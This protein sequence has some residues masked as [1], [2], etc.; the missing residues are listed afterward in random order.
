MNL[1]NKLTIARLGLTFFFVASFAFEFQ[2]RFTVAFCIFLTAAI[3]DFLDGEIARREN[4][5]TDFGKLMDPLADKILTASAFISLAAFNAIP[6]WAVI[7]IIS[8]EFL[9]TGLRTLAASK[10]IMLPADKLGKHKTTWQMITIIFFLLILSVGEF[11]KADWLDTAWLIGTHLLVPI[12]VILSLYSGLA[13]L[14]KNR[15]LLDGR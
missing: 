3:T 15:H 11:I 14:A 12:T 8:R 10:N 13:Y 2:W 1:P 9:I 5:I 6:Q 7:L 4:L